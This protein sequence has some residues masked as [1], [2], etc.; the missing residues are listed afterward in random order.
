MATAGVELYAELRRQGLGD[1]DLAVVRQAISNLS[2]NTDNAG[3]AET[4]TKGTAAP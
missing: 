3:A 2:D 4:A 1:K